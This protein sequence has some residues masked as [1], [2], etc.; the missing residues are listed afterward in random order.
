MEDFGRVL[1]AMVTPF[2]E[3]LNVDYK[4]AGQLAKM[5]E[6]SGSDGI[7]VS[8]TTGESPT[9]TFEEKVKLYETVREVVSPKTAVIAG[10]GT[11]STET[12]IKLTKEAEAVGVDGIMAVVPY[13]NKPSQ[14][15]L[16]QHFKAVAASTKLPV[17]LYNVPPRT[18]L[19]MKPETVFR[20]SQ[21]DN[22]VALKEAANDVEQATEIKR[23]CSPDF[24]IYSG[25]D[26]FTLP[27]LSL[28]GY[29][30]V[31]VASHI[32]GNEIKEMINHFFNGNLE[33]SLE[34]HI[35]LFPL[36]KVLFIASNPVPVK[37]ALKLKGFDV[38]GV[39]L[40]LVNL[41]EKEIGRAHV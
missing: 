18:S 23:I 25:N 17:M 28:G 11:N 27:L 39:R 24:K 8:G 37:T 26:S 9:L 20:L 22:I 21:I 38:G 35:K 31:S 30:V 5:L 34:I 7:I 3:K 16:Y 33:K 2:D 14:E 15:G 6:S 29:G 36:F 12:S 13:Y 19:N 40:P 4:K 10:T 32:A 1:T 41:T